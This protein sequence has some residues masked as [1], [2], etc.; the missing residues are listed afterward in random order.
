MIA[1]NVAQG[2][3]F[4][5]LPNQ[6]SWMALEHLDELLIDVCRLPKASW[7]AETAPMQGAPASTLFVSTESGLACLVPDVMALGYRVRYVGDLPAAA[8]PIAYDGKFWVPLRGANGKLVVIAVDSS[9][10]VVTR[11]ELDADVDAGAFSAPV[12]YGRQ[13]LWPSSK[14][15]LRL[16]KQQDGKVS[17]TF[18]PWPVNVAPS[19]EFGSA[20]LS[21]DGGIWQLC[22]DSAEGR[23]VY[24]RIDVTADEVE[25]TTSPRQCSG[26]VNYRFAQRTNLPPWEEPSHGDDSGSNEFV[27]PLLEVTESGQVLG[28]R[29][30]AR[31]AIADTL[32]STERLPAELILEDRYGSVV[33]HTLSAQEPWHIRL[34]VHDHTLWA[35]H[36]RLRRLEGWR[37]EQ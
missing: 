27:I 35:Y 5:W 36:A 16:L 6:D 31:G 25:P 19:F 18:T 22:F 1:L 32:A 2:N 20:Y 3:L 11:Q 9:G 28:M 4:V 15:R 10:E 30:Q 21:G 34:F 26:R 29:L 24:V 12:A 33:F 14:G 13:A 8:S 7:R 37:L 23:Y 17:L